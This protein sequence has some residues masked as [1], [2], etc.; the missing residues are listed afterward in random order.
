MTYDNLEKLETNE[1]LSVWYAE[2]ANGPEARDH[3]A[4]FHITDVKNRRTFGI[5]AASFI[6]GGAFAE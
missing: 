4:A 2:L 5:T 3:C 6:V 1:V